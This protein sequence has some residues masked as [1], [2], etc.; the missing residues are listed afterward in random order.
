MLIEQRTDAH[1]HADC[2]EP[3]AH[4]S[5]QQDSKPV[6]K[7]RD[8]KKR[9][10]PKARVIEINE[11]DP[12]LTLQEGA[13]RAKCHI[14]TLRRLIKAGLLRHARVGAGRKHIRVRSSWVDSAMEACSTP[15]ET[16]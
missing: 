1:T 3:P 12:W 4:P 11:A 8:R 16:R 13:A 5:D 2:N 9:A 7:K 6:A 14:A 10:R 15:V